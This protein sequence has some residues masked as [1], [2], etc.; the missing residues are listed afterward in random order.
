M[1]WYCST[2]P[3]EHPDIWLLVFIST[4]EDCTLR[5]LHLRVKKYQIKLFCNL[6]SRARPYWQIWSSLPLSGANWEK[7]AR[8]TRAAGDHDAVSCLERPSNLSN[9]SLPLTQDKSPKRTNL[10]VPPRIK[11]PPGK[12]WPGQSQVTVL[13]NVMWLTIQKPVA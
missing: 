12:L 9:L 10:V 8:V 6:L 1:I 4:L 11:V 5:L 7:C 13:F 2:A 3:I